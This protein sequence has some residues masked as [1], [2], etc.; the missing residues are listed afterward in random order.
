MK[1]EVLI[2]QV[3]NDVPVVS[4]EFLGAR[5]FYAGGDMVSQLDHHH[6]YSGQIYS[7]C[8]LGIRHPYPPFY[9]LP[10]CQT[11]QLAVCQM[12]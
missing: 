7:L 4:Q 8:S 10:V 6:F 3:G 9:F 1:Q 11:M 5:A 12:D 2:W